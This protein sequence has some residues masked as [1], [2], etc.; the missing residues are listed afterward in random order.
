[1]AGADLGI[2][3]HC[4]KIQSFSGW[5][6]P[7]WTWHAKVRVTKSKPNGNAPSVVQGSVFVT[8]K[9]TVFYLMRIAIDAPDINLRTAGKHIYYL[10]VPKFLFYIKSAKNKW[11]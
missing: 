2:S 4:K 11:N 9:K 3:G 10:L 8:S 1:M 5:E 6:H 7:G